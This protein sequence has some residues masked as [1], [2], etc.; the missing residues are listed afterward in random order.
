[1]K[2]Q[3]VL[4]Q[5]ISHS[6]FVCFEH[7]SRTTKTKSLEIL[8]FWIYCG[9]LVAWVLGLYV[10]IYKRQRKFNSYQCLMKEL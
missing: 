8:S 4:M 6:F 5:T 10:N 3:T 1:M 9:V 2:N 7:N